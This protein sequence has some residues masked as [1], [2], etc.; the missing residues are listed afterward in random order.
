MPSYLWKRYGMWYSLFSLQI[1]QILLLLSAM[2]FCFSLCFSSPTRTLSMFMCELFRLTLFSPPIDQNLQLSTLTLFLSLPNVL[3]HSPP[4]SPILN[5]NLKLLSDF[6]F[7][8]LW[9]VFVIV[10]VIVNVHPPLLLFEV[11]VRSNSN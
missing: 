6:L 11:P 3:F 1:N 8:R 10:I 4:L 5:Q 2:F 7:P 9:I